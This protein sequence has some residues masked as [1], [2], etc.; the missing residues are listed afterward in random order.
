MGRE[1]WGSRWNRPAEGETGKNE[2]ERVQ[3]RR[4]DDNGNEGNNS[5]V[6]LKNVWRRK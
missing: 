3:G 2:S 1:E 5:N 6:Q 4:E